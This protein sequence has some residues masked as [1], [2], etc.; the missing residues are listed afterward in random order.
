MYASVYEA[1]GF[2][3]G[4]SCDRDSIDGRSAGPPAAGRRPLPLPL[5]GHPMMQTEDQQQLHHGHPPAPPLGAPSQ[6]HPPQGRRPP[7]MPPVPP[8]VPGPSKSM[9]HHPQRWVLSSPWPSSSL[10]SPHA[11]EDLAVMTETFLFEDHDDGDHL[12]H[13]NPPRLDTMM[14]NSPVVEGVVVRSP[15][16]PSHGDTRSGNNNNNNSNK[17]KDPPSTATVIAADGSDPPPP[18]PASSSNSLRRRRPWR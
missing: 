10:P 9:G 2:R 14:G 13:R 5:S 3:P 4:R 17:R 18:P 6:C 1:L 8:P 7:T 15:R 11:V 16:P 12:R